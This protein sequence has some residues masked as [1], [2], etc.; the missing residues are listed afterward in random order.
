MKNQITVSAVL[1]LI[2]ANGTATFKGHSSHSGI[3]EWVREA[4]VSLAKNFDFPDLMWIDLQS[5]E[6]NI[7]FRLRL[8]ET[9]SQKEV[10]ALRVVGRDGLVLGDIPVNL[11]TPVVCAMAVEDNPLALEHVPADC[12]TKQMCIDAALKNGESARFIP[13]AFFDQE[14]CDLIVGADRGAFKH[15]PTRFK[16]F[17]MSVKVVSRSQFLLKCV[18]D[19]IRLAVQKAVAG[20]EIKAAQNI[21]ESHGVLECQ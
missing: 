14:I 6:S 1:D 21:L 20:Q 18:P 7:R 5:V 16:T 12:K 9:K 17:A 2:T 3:A 10:H 11:R 19:L 15:I 4:E 8:A 13:K